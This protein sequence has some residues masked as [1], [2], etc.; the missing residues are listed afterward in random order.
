MKKVVSLLCGLVAAVE[1]NP[2]TWVDNVK[3][4][5]PEGNMTEY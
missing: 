3:I 5:T 1:P 2:P 4:F